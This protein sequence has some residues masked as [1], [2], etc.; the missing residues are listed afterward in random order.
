MEF[1]GRLAVW[2]YPVM[3]LMLYL[4]VPACVS[5]IFTQDLLGDKVTG[6]MRL[7]AITQIEQNSLERLPTKRYDHAE[8]SLIRTFGK[9]FLV[10][11]YLILKNQCRI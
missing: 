9:R 4:I 1:P 6:E 11:R 3:S 5:Y 10:S 7:P 8:L 2:P